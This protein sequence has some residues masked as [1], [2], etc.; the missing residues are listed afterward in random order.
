[1]K[2]GRRRHH[3]GVPCDAEVRADIADLLDKEETPDKSDSRGDA[4]GMLPG[5][6]GLHG[7][8]RSRVS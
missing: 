1:M 7:D 5:A 2:G 8:A 4:M 6:L 3:L